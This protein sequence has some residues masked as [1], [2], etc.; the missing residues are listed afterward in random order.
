MKQS[1]QKE[2]K[3]YKNS[4]CEYCLY[5]YSGILKIHEHPTTKKM[6]IICAK[7]WSNLQKIIKKTERT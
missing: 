7:C 5:S 3:I 2:I 6:I 4:E 1:N